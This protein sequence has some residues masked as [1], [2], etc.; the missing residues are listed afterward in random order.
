MRLSICVTSDVH[1]YITPSNYRNRVEENMGL[2]KVATLLNKLRKNKDTILIDNGDFIQGSPFTYYFAKKATNYKNPMIKVANQLKYDLAV[3]G[4]H[5]F[6]YGMDYLQRA[7]N[8]SDFPWLSANVVNTMDQ[9]PFLGKPY[10]IKQIGDIRIAV[11]GMTTHF[12]PNWEDPNHI[13]DLQFEDVCEST[14][15][16]VPLIRELEKPDIM[17]VSY[18]GGLERDPETGE[19]TEELT[20]ENQAYQICQEVEGIDLLITG[21]QHRF[22]TGEIKGVPFV[23]PGNNGQALAEIKIEYDEKILSI[24]PTLH[25]VDNETKVDHHVMERIRNDEK[26]VQDFLDQTI[27]TVEG[28]MEITDPMGVRLKGHPFIHYI[29]Q[30]QMKVAEVD[31]SCTALFHDKSPGFPKQVTMRDIVSNYIY[32]NTL[33]VL[34]ISGYDIKAALEK[35]ASYFQV[36]AGEI[37]VNPSYLT[38]KPQPY[39]YDMWQGIYYEILLSNPMGERVITINYH[40]KPMDM[41]QTYHVVMNNY[42][43]SG[44]GDYSMF[45]G[46]EV[47]KDI[48]LDM[49]EVITNDL[50]KREKLQAEYKKHFQIF[51]N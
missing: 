6:N 10:V 38:P 50:L 22:L 44:G 19:A 23:Q 8:E 46:K 51:A 9:E 21:H 42:R 5:E 26:Q 18:H 32:P 47:V 15:K 28:D 43:A 36:E 4:N 17:I 24:K 16:W 25:Y 11:L 33:K 49:T 34:E 31:I 1:G 27:T 12:I 40:G 13:K 2:A 35:A 20:G 14:K 45:K 29:N 37:V 30:L 48:P 3:I 41:N 39:N 7:V